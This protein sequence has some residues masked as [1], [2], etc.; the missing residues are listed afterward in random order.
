MVFCDLFLCTFR[1]EQYTAVTNA[2]SVFA[3]NKLHLFS[4]V[5]FQN[6]I[7]ADD[8]DEAAEGTEEE[9]QPA[10]PELSDSAASADAPPSPDDVD[11]DE[12]PAE[13]EPEQESA[14]SDSAPSDSSQLG[15]TAPT[16]TPSGDGDSAEPPIGDTQPPSDGEQSSQPPPGLLYLFQNRCLNNI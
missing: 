6:V 5:L 13:G 7:F 3:S 2:Y 16:E 4:I 1:G 15:D 10:D 8:G 11:T 9:S 14:P 12:K